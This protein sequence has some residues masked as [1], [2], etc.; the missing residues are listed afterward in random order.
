MGVP[1]YFGAVLGFPDG[2]CRVLSASRGSAAADVL[3]IDSVRLLKEA[4]FGQ[5]GPEMVF[6]FGSRF[7]KN[8]TGTVDRPVSFES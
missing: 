5:T 1:A 6:L 4:I 8:S 2:C 3:R 7:I